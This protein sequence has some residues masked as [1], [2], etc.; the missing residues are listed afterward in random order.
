MWWHQSPLNTAMSPSTGC[1]RRDGV[2]GRARRCRRCRR[3]GSHAAGCCVCGEWAAPGGGVRGHCRGCALTCLS[4]LVSTPL[5]VLSRQTC[6]SPRSA[7]SPAQHRRRQRRRHSTLGQPSRSPSLALKDCLSRSPC[8]YL[9]SPPA[10]KTTQQPRRRMRQTRRWVMMC[11]T[12][13]QWTSNALQ[14]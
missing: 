14:R 8:P 1:V 6:S 4:L 12:H 7:C 3:R 10:P 13:P 9:V 11:T 5:T 2:R